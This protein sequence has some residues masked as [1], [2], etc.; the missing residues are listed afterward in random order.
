MHNISA[1][2]GY[3]SA[4]LTLLTFVMWIIC[5]VLI[6]LKPPL[7]TWTNLQDYVQYFHSGSQTLQ[8]TARFFMLIFGPVYVILIHS[9]Y[10]FT[11]ERKKGL[12][13]LSLLF[14]LGFAVL[15]GMNYF[16][17]LSAV[18]L[19]LLHGQTR[20]LEYFVQ[21]NPLSVLT[22][23]DMTGWTLF[24]GLSSFFIFPVF[25]HNGSDNILRVAF[26]VNGIS[27]MLGGVG[28]MLQIDILTFLAINVGVGG[29][30]MTIAVT[31]AGYFK[32]LQTARD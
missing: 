29:A 10:D 30:V 20:G 7:F 14:A 18:R 9:F 2:T 22:S 17:Q 13:R 12:I 27:C 15:S 31:S 32:R 16:V 5:F 6:A 4:L 21:A 8:N 24:L 3:W 1:K 19:N 23:I 28:Y 11:P 25:G 26:L